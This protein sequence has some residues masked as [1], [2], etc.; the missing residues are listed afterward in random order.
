[1]ASGEATHARHRGIRRWVRVLLILLGAYTLWLLAAFLLQRSVLFPR[2]AATELPGARHALPGLV[3][4][5][6][7]SAEGAV[8]AWFVPAPQA[9]AASP[10][11]LAVFWHGNA[12]L[13]DHQAPL[14]EA[15]LRLGLSV[16]LPEYRGYGRSAGSPSEEALVADG[17]RALEAALARPDVDPTRVV[18][19]GRSVGAAVA[20]A[21]AV[22]RAPAALVL[23][24]PFRS[25]AAL[26]GRFLIPRPLVRDPF[27][28]EA[29]LRGLACPV[30]VF[31]GTADGIVPYAHGER[32]AALARHGTLVTYPGGHNDPP[33]DDFAHWAHVE[34]HLR[35]AGVLR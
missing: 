15:Y 3:D 10:A 29:A 2:G 31:H 7:A 13:I 17:L 26:A 23:E 25:V 14:V 19:H 9:S 6:L 22:R 1:M 24:S 33:P 34:R 27:D 28:N 18:H 30:L 16:L 8:E 12:E 5:P 21:V 32:L 20:C 4:L 11:A 35:K